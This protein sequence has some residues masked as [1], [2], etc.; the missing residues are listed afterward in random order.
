[1]V[2]LTI[3]KSTQNQI[4]KLY[5]GT[6][7]QAGLGARAIADTL[8]VPRRQVMTVLEEKGVAEFSPGSYT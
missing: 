6:K 2:A 4:V 1:M 8:G 7:K 3:G 5:Q